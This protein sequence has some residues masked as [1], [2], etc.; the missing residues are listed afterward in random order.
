V[1]DNAVIDMAWTEEQISFIQAVAEL[2]QLGGAKAGSGDLLSAIVPLG[3]R[4]RSVTPDEDLLLAVAYPP[5][6]LA[7]LVDR[8][9]EHGTCPKCGLERT[10][11][12]DVDRGWWHERE[13]W[14]YQRGCSR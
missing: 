1:T 11:R 12:T 14:G 2:M 6:T 5:K 7:E 4:F 8:I 9:T 10:R 3:L 13:P